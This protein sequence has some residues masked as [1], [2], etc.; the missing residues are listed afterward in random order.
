MLCSH[1]VALAQLPHQSQTAPYHRR[2]GPSLCPADVPS[3][4]E[5]S[6]HALPVQ[7]DEKQRDHHDRS[8]E[9]YI[10]PGAKPSESDVQHEHNCYRDKSE[11]EKENS[12]GLIA[13]Q[14]RGVCPPQM[15]EHIRLPIEGS[16]TRAG[17]RE[18]PISHESRET[19]IKRTILTG[20]LSGSVG[21]VADGS[22]CALMRSGTVERCGGPE[23]VVWS[24]MRK[25]RSRR[26]T[27]PWLVAATSGIPKLLLS[28]KGGD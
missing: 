13:Y 24:A 23:M 15:Q 22:N 7:R 21:R 8:S 4:F 14:L 12:T 27:R 20:I 17:L 11:E 2:C 16:V 18:L 5:S 19:H 9:A 26:S 3:I 1:P 25:A 10:A 6:V 28:L